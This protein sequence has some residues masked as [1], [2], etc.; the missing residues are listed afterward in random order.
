MPEYIRHSREHIKEISN[1][2]F[3]VDVLGRKKFA[4]LLTNIVTNYS[5]G[6]VMALNGAWG[7][8]KSVFLEQWRKQLKSDGYRVTIFNA[9]D[10]DYFGEPTLAILSQF[11]DF[12]DEDTPLSHKAVAAWKT[13]QKAPTIVVKNLIKKGLSE[14]SCDVIDEKVIEEISDSYN[15]EV[16]QCYRNSD[17]G[18][19]VSQRIEFIKYKTSLIE[20]AAEASVATEAG[21]Y[22]K[23]LVFII[24]ELDRCS[25]SY[26]VEVLEKVKHL[27]NIPN[28]VF[29]IAVDKEQLKCTIQGYYGAYNFNAEEYLRRFFDIELDLPPIKYI[30]FAKLLSEHFNFKNCIWSDDNR[31]EFIN[32]S[33]TMAEKHHLSLRQLEKY[34]A[35]AKLVFSSYGRVDDSEWLIAILLIIYKFENGTFNNIVNKT[36]SLEDYA[37]SLKVLFDF[38]E[39][40]NGPNLLGALLYFIDSYLQEGK[41]VSVPNDF[42]FPWSSQFSETDLDKMSRSYHAA[43]VRDYRGLP[44]SKIIDKICFI[45]QFVCKVY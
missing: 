28:I 37:N 25:P 39:F 2:P 45:E 13:L 22:N 33:A 18:N 19:Y 38:S 24:D 8:G 27:F 1:E 4:N 11:K 36:Y 3:G 17:I 31:T 9:W 42:K 20:F 10:N 44:L 21:T 40:S 7:T 34:F 6:F 12:F 30:E 16:E 29:C 23:P 26:A 14:I 41:F 5:T 35:H 15:S 32:I 43:S